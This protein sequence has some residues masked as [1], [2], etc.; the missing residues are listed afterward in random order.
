M[1]RAAKANVYD[2]EI[3][4]SVLAAYL[5]RIDLNNCSN[6]TIEFSGNEIAEILKLPSNVIAADE[7]GYE[8]LGWTFKLD[9]MLGNR[10]EYLPVFSHVS[11]TRIAAGEWSITLSGSRTILNFLKNVYGKPENA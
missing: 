8:L 3:L 5:K 10:N 9:S 1:M 11:V 4:L 2:K 6:N 7:L